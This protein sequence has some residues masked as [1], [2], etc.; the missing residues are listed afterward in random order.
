MR[1]T[2][3]F[4]ATFYS[5]FYRSNTK[6]SMHLKSVMLEINFEKKKFDIYNELLDTTVSFIFDIVLIHDIDKKNIKCL[7]KVSIPLRSNSER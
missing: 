6:C 2:L 5:A 7:Y 3:Y 1:T 4:H